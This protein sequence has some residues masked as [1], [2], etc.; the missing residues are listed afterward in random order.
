LELKISD[1]AIQDLDLLVAYRL[2]MWREIHPKLEAEVQ[3][4]AETTREWI[5]SRLSEGRLVGFIVRDEHGKVAGS[6]CVW[7]R[8]EQPRLTNPRQQNPYL[9]SMYTEREFRRKGVA[10]IIVKEAIDWCRER[11]YERIV[12]HA[13]NEGR[14]LY[15]SFG[16]E[17]ANE[18]RLR[19]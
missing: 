8:D 10:K 4:S 12:L 19:L 13:S 18:L 1:A 17:P 2:E 5:K 14:P 3:E 7:I 11:G 15:A 16:F 6:G 9:M